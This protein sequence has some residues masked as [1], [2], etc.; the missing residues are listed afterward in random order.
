MQ[1]PGAISANVMTS[2][3]QSMSA[4]HKKI[5]MVKMVTEY[6][7]AL[8]ALNASGAQVDK[9]INAA[10]AM[11]TA[12]AAIDAQYGDYFRDPAAYLAANNISDKTIVQ[13]AINNLYTAAWTAFQTATASS[14]SEIDAMKAGIVLTFPGIQLPPDFGKNYNGSPQPTNWP[15]Q[16][17]VMVNWM[18]NIIRNGGSI[19]Y[20]R[21]TTPIPAMMENWMGVCSN[22]QY[23]DKMNCQSNGGIWTA[24][25]H[26]FASGSVAF[27]AYL[28]LQ[29]DVNLADM[30]R[31]S[32]WS[33]GNQPTQ[34]ERMQ[35]QADF[36]ALLETIK[37][38]FVAT[39]DA[40][41]SVASD[42]EKKA[43][44]KLMLQPN[45]D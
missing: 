18:V 2:I 24:Q 15:V 37:G 43:V 7:N 12:T 8:S 42:M 28:G 30:T 35:S 40:A 19:T 1:G 14:D 20:T 25:R 9:F 16:Q 32:I 34:D 17:V 3:D 41:G 45:S 10:K 26:T 33:N 6:T 31:N 44:I 23:W 22:T 39:K 27:N 11:S 21:D 5:G 36:I 4:F 38:K 13:T 29:E